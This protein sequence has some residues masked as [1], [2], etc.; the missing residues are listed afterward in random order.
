MISPALAVERA[1]A[2]QPAWAA[3]PLQG[4]LDCLKNLRHRIAAHADD[5]VSA[6][7]ALPGREPSL[8]LT[9]E[10]APLADAIRFLEREAPAL[11][12]PRRLGARGRPIWL[13]G[14]RAEIRHEPLGVVLVIGPSNFPLLLPGVQAM[15]ALAAGNAAV[16]KPGAN[17]RAAMALLARLAADAGIDPAL[18][19][20]LD[21]TP[22]DA[23]AAIAA[24]VDK[25]VLTGGVAAGRAVLRELAE[26]LIPSTM[27]LSGSD[28]VFVLPGADL[29]LVAKSL[30]WGLAFNAGAACIAP[31]RV[32]APRAAMVE[33]QDKLWPLIA[34]LKPQPVAR[35]AA[36]N[37]ARLARAAIEAGA[38]PLL[39]W[40]PPGADG[41]FAPLALADADPG[42]ALIREDVFA[43]VLALVA[44]DDTDRALAADADCPY[45]LGASVFGPIA[46]AREFALRVRAGV[47]TINDLIVPSADPRLPFGGSGLSGFGRTRG[48]EGLLEM[49]AAK[50][51]TVRH[52]GFRPH[53]DGGDNAALARHYLR[54]AHGRGLKPR[55]RAMLKLIGAM[56]RLKKKD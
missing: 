25:A 49:T 52:G 10:I 9:A 37:A 8:S 13:F 27:E 14:N 35:P 42:M 51:V 41:A 47:V 1:R 17:G 50:A 40:S 31:R 15:Q 12:R 22:D 56:A 53:L 16:V 34:D 11:L 43:P 30:A 7:A 21:E 44:V 3:M 4:R 5:L 33:L 18:L 45:A 6:L 54:A 19:P 38:R 20:V 29:N 46:A 26:R 28:A 2:A 24:G 55:A 23:R 39:P 48:A 36:E 32:F